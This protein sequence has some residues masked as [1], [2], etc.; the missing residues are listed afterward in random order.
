VETKAAFKQFADYSSS[1]EVTREERAILKTTKIIMA[2]EME[3]LGLYPF[4]VASVL[5]R[6]KPVILFES[7]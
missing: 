3:R 2:F 1:I 4:V 6:N 7:G 5:T